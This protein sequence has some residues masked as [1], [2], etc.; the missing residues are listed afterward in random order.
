MIKKYEMLNTNGSLSFCKHMAFGE[1]NFIISHDQSIVFESTAFCP[2]SIIQKNNAL[3]QY[4]GSAKI[5]FYLLLKPFR[6]LKCR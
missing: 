5:R 1:I 4:N 2:L 3:L 6:Y